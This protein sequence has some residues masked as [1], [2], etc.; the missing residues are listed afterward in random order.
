MSK[1]PSQIRIVPSEKQYKGAPTLDG[2]LDVTLEGQKRLM[3][4]G[5]RTVILNLAERF[6]KERQ[7]SNLIRITAMF[8]IFY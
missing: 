5:D 1:E 2:S 4:D 8:Y 6:D 7:G 3:V